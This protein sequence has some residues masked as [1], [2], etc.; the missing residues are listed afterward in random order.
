MVKHSSSFYVTCSV[1]P[2]SSVGKSIPH[3]AARGH[4]SGSAPYIDDYVPQLGELWVDFF[5]SPIA[6]G[7]IRAIDVCRAR[8]IPGVVGIYARR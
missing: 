8:K 2:M 4:V 1:H 7:R 3:D 6:A 5:G